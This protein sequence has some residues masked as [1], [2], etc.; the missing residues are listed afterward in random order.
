MS[1][2]FPV[3]PTTPPAGVTAL[4]GSATMSSVT[5]TS[6]PVGATTAG[7]SGGYLIGPFTPKIGYDLWCKIIGSAASGT[8]QLLKSDDAG[9]TQNSLTE[10]GQ[11]WGLWTFSSKTGVIVNEPPVTPSDSGLFYLQLAL[12]SGSVTFRMGQ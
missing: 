7:N 5:L 3:S 6:I 8:A 9:N 10:G 4:V 11:P 12:T 2:G 1:S